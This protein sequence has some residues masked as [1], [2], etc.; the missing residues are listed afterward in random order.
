MLLLDG[1]A[2]LGLNE[3][4]MDYQ[5]LF[6]IAVGIAGVVSGWIFH[7]MYDSLRELQKAYFRLNE[8]IQKVSLVVA[9]DYVKREQFEKMAETLFGKIDR[10]EDKIEAEVD[11]LRNKID[12]AQ[13][14]V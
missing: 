2:Q 13:K 5:I 11:K 8:Q 10:L 7:I 6:N 4:N 12:E 3:V 9:G 1:L 14:S